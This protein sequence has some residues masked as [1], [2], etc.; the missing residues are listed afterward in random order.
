MSLAFLLLGETNVAFFENARNADIRADGYTTPERPRAGALGALDDAAEVF[1]ETFLREE[2]EAV[3]TADVAIQ[4]NPRLSSTVTRHPVENGADVT[5]HIHLEPEVLSIEG[6]QTDTPSGIEALLIVPG[7]LDRFAS[8][9]RSIEAWDTLRGL[10]DNKR[11]LDV[12]TSL[13]VFT[14]MAITSI[15]A[16]MTAQVG[17][18]L[19][20]SLTLEKVRFVSTATVSTST[21]RPDGTPDT[22]ERG[23]T[24]TL[25][26]GS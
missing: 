9:P 24:E 23:E 1:R 16:P 13:E 14:D 17:R 25:A 19:R 26:A 12:L 21:L 15:S 6:L 5:D 8:V 2:P 11:I 18:A 22:V 4:I 10:R 7:L 3:F 20:F